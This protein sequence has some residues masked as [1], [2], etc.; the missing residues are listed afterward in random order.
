MAL[1]RLSCCP[2]VM[3]AIPRKN[4]FNFY[5]CAIPY[6]TIPCHTIPKHAIMPYR[7]TPCHAI[8]Y[9]AIP[10]HT[11]H[12]TRSLFICRRSFVLI[13]TMCFFVSNR[14]AWI[15]F[16]LLLTPHTTTHPHSFTM[17]VIAFIN[18]WRA[19]WLSTWYLFV[20]SRFL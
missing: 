1:H 12:N 11:A 17:W 7:S 10:Y 15:V 2:K 14:E 13:P 20:P 9:D 4:L 5:D 18:N 19:G 16:F 6:H 8:P 3:P